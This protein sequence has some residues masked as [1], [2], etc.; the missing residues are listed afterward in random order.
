MPSTE[1][2]WAVDLKWARVIGCGDDILS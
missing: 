1:D 2:Q